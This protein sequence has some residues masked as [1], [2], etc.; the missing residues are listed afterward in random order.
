[1]RSFLFRFFYKIDQIKRV[2]ATKYNLI[3]YCYVFTRESSKNVTIR[4]KV[5]FNPYRTDTTRITL[6]D[7]VYIERHTTFQGGG[8]LN[9]GRCTTIGEFTIIGCNMKI[10]IGDYVQIASGC[11]IRDSNHVIPKNHKEL[12]T[13]SGIES[14]P[15]IIEDDVW[16]AANVSILKGVKIGKGSVI[17]AN[18]VVTKDIPPYSIAAGCPAKVIKKR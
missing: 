18:S 17:G 7:E 13:A 2:I 4:N 16:I 3:R 1:M 9:I 10:D 12:I 11:S 5:R 6:K 15:V 8:I 14:E